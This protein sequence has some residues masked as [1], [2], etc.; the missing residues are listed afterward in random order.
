MKE[1]RLTSAVYTIELFIL[2]IFLY[3]IYIPKLIV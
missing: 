1:L 2:I 3:I